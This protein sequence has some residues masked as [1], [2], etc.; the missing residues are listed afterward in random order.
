[1]AVGDNDVKLL[2]FHHALQRM[3]MFAREIH[4]LRDFGLRDLV[5]EHATFAD[6]VMMNMQHDL[7]G[8][9]HVLLK[10]LL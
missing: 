7:G 5:S 1:M 2:L 6:A 8:R 9:F 4:H 10:E 3:L